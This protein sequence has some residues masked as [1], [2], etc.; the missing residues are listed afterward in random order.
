MWSS[1]SFDEVRIF[2]DMKSDVVYYATFT[3]SQRTLKLPSLMVEDCLHYMET[4]HDFDFWWL[5]EEMER[6]LSQISDP[7]EYED[8]ATPSY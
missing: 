4:F 2:L 8:W 6:R 1:V 7:V 3:N 5:E